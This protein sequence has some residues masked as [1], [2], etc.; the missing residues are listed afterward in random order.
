M[1]SQNLGNGKVRLS[2]TAPKDDHSTTNLGYVVRLGTSKG[3]SEL[4]NTESDLETGTRLIV[5]TAPIYT[6]QVITIGQFKL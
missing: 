2:W 3:G 6:I 4:S 5:K 1:K